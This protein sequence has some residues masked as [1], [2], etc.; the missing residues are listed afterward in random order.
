[1]NC[2][3][4]LRT[5]PWLLDDEIEPA[6]AV[7]LE[8]HLNH[9]AACREAYEHEGRF[10]LVLRR[11]AASVTAPPALRSRLREVL[12]AE[13]RRQNGI[14]QLWPAVAAAVI[15]L[16]FIWRGTGGALS[17]A[18]ELEAA[19]ARHAQNL[20]MDVVTADVGQVQRFFSDRLPFAVHVPRMGNE[21]VAEVAGRITQL[22]NRDA[23]YVRYQM[24]RGRMSFFVYED[25]RPELNEGTAFYQIG[26]QR[27]QVQRVRGFTVARWRSAGVVYSVVTDL[28]ESDFVKAMDLG[29]R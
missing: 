5:I 14:Y 28:P 19:A 6:A 11:A 24:P 25:N 7:E 1:M 18:P 23:A 16:A 20:P 27:V 3:E 10:R 4:A 15:L 26:K 29:E 21:P 9:C 13:R 17:W 22:N 12:D 2:D 8:A